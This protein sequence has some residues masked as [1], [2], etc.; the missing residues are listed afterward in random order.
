MSSRLRQLTRQ[1]LIYLNT[2]SLGVI[3]FSTEL[4]L[5]MNGPKVTKLS[6]MNALYSLR[7]DV[8]TVLSSCVVNIY[9]VITIFFCC[10]LIHFVPQWQIIFALEA[11][12]DKS[13]CFIIKSKSISSVSK[14]ESLLLEC[15]KI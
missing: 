4:C 5:D 14:I 7:V 9:F 15:K 13:S 11:F 6:H 1:V 12:R 10:N 8:C 3:T 2:L